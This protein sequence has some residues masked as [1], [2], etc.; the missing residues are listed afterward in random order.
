MQLLYCPSHGCSQLKCQ[1]LRVGGYTE[2]VLEW[3]NYP[4]ARA[5]SG[6]EVNCQGVSHRHFVLFQGQPDSGESCIMLQSWPTHSLIA[7]FPQHSVVACSTQISCCRERTLWTRPWMGVCEP[8]LWHPK[9]NSSY[10]SSANLPSDSICKNLAWW[11]V[12]RRT[13]KN[14]K[15]GGWRLLGYGHFLGTIR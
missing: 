7:K 14:H 3:F 6:C 13:S 2:K 4:C 12:T 1:K 8:L 15:T 9:R 5:H 10:V 11:A